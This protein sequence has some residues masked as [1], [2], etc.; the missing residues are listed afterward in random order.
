M[1]KMLLN[2]MVLANAAVE[3]KMMRLME[4]SAFVKF[5]EK[6]EK[7]APTDTFYRQLMSI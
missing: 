1:H 2:E 3:Q 4:K 7:K 5:S 6:V